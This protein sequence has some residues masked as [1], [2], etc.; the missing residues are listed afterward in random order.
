M[1]QLI[2]L[3]FHVWLRPEMFCQGGKGVGSTHG[4]DIRRMFG[5]PVFLSAGQLEI[6]SSGAVR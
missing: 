6:N 1:C 2:S 3:F 4:R 5:I